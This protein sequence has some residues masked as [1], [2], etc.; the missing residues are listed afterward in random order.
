MNAFRPGA[1]S[2]CSALESSTVP[3]EAL[4][5]SMSGDWPVTVTLSSIAPTSSSRSRTR[6]C[7]VPMRM[8]RRSTVLNPWSAARTVYV[9][10]STA[11]KT[12]SPASLLTTDRLM[13]VDS[14]VIVTSTPGT[15]PLGSRTA[16]RN[17]P[18]NPCPAASVAA[19][20][21]SN[22]ASTSTT[23]HFI[24]PPSVE[25]DVQVETGLSYHFLNATE[26][27]EMRRADSKTTG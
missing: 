17:P 13:L 15:T 2:V 10:G 19:T 21:N 23:R 20:A 24:V 9:P 25:Q 4:A 11:A 5:V 6:N 3:C 26:R 22:A 8:P 16:P 12:Y 18:W 14:F 7:C 1:G 27:Q